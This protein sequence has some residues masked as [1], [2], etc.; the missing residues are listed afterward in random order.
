MLEVDDAM[1]KLKDHGIII[2][3]IMSRTPLGGA[4]FWGVPETLTAF[5][6]LVFRC[7]RGIL[8]ILAYRILMF[9]WPFGAPTPDI[10]SC[11]S[12]E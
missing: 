1:A 9:V 2:L 3:V 5:Y 6:L 4:V 12:Y 8:E 11:K 10:R 7:N